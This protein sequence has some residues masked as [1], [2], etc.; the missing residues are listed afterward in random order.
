M[1]VSNKRPI[2]VENLKRYRRHIEGWIKVET[3]TLFSGG[4]IHFYYTHSPVDIKFSHH[5]WAIIYLNY[6][7]WEFWWRF[8]TSKKGMKMK[9]WN[10]T[11]TKKLWKEKNYLIISNEWCFQPAIL[12]CCHFIIMIIVFLKH[13]N[14]IQTS[15]LLLNYTTRHIN[16]YQS[17]V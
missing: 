16:S 13:K 11:T 8:C 14:K 10:A 15:W 12:T 7:F 2:Q 17:K 5:G 6:I 4:L 3:V 1:V 9:C